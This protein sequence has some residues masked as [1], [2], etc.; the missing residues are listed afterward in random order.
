MG[1]T[2]SLLNGYDRILLHSIALDAFSV[3]GP[4]VWNDAAMAATEEG[5]EVVSQ[6]TCVLPSYTPSIPKRCPNT[7]YGP[8][9]RY[10]GFHGL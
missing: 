5:G 10:Y 6:E 8:G 7:P 2:T 1:V 9:T 3:C 4:N